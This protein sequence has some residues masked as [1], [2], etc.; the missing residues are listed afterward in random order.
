MKRA[1]KNSQ[2]MLSQENKDRLSK[3]VITKE[4]LP[5][6][7]LVSIFLSKQEERLFEDASR[8]SMENE[9]VLVCNPH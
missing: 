4:I 9:K 6:N 1:K 5:K 8:Q 7:V 2:I 3:G